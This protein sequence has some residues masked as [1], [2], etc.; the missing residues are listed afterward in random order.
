[1]VAQI[2]M[3]GVGVRFE[4]QPAVMHDAEKLL[5]A[6]QAVATEH[7]FAAQAWEGGELFEGEVEEGVGIHFQQ[8]QE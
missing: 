6:V 7:A 5:A 1:M 8:N 4:I 2:I 3:Q